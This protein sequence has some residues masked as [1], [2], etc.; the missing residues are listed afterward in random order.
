MFPILSQIKPIPKIFALEEAMNTPE[1]KKN[2][3]L[4]C[5]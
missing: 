3:A 4:L 1:G 5:L 2:I